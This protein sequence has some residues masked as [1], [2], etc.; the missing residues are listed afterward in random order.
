MYIMDMFFKD[1]DNI[2]DFGSIRMVEAKKGNIRTYT[3]L[4]ADVSKLD[5]ITNAYSGSIAYCVDTG[6]FYV[7]HGTTWYKQ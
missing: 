5:L 1:K 7:K 3:L 6:D 2:P 4:S